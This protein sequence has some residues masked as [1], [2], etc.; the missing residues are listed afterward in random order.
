MLNK[1][2]RKTDAVNALL[3]AIRIL[4][5]YLRAY[6]RLSDIYQS[7]GETD[8]AIRVL[9]D[10]L[11]MAPGTGLIIQKLRAL[12]VEPDPRYLYKVEKKADAVNVP[13]A[14]PLSGDDG[15][16]PDQNGKE[17]VNPDNEKNPYCRF[18]AD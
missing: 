16:G 18:C 15:Q 1:L 2:D 10:G 11:R 8:K 4:P 17:S 7:A 12:G 3:K 14:T 13:A 5:D 9:E 6:V